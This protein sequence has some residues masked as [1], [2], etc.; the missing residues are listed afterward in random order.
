VRQH[1]KGYAT[2]LPLQIGLV[3]ATVM[4]LLTCG[5]CNF[6]GMLATWRLKKA[7]PAEIF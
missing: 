4:Y 7:D 6:S 5:M 2:L 3:W 1:F